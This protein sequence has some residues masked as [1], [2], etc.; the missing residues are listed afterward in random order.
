M[1]RRVEK[2]EDNRIVCAYCGERLRDR[3]EWIGHIPC[4]ETVRVELGKVL[5]ANIE[6]AD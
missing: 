3:E 4:K 1:A 2:G 5:L 6:V